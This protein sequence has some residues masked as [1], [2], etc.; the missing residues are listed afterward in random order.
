LR[1]RLLIVGDGEERTNLEEQSRSLGLDDLVCFV[2]S[3]PQAQ[4]QNYLWAAD[5]F[6]CVNELSN[7]GNPLLEAMIAGRCILTLDE[8]DTRDLIRDGETGVLLPPTGDPATIAGALATLAKDPDRRRRL[9]AAAHRLAQRSFWSWQERID[10]EVEAVTGL[11]AGT[12][13]RV[14]T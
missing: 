14:Q 13:P 11:V 4:V 12:H 10:A 5:V 7:V 3:V 2:G 1:A 6:L 8:G 9:G